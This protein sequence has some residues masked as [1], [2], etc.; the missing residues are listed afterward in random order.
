M[1]DQID[2]HCKPICKVESTS[3]SLGKRC[4]YRIKAD[5]RG[6][7][8]T[9]GLVSLLECE[10]NAYGQSVE[11]QVYAAASAKRHQLLV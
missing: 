4:G 7:A 6:G 10:F 3:F 2:D 11:G 5:Q 9:F 8:F 1:L